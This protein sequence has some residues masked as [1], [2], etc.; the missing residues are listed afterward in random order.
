VSQPIQAPAASLRIL[1][2]DDEANIRAALSRFLDK[3]G[4]SVVTVDS[5]TGALEAVAKH[6]FDAIFLDIRMPDIS[7]INVFEQWQ[8]EQPR[9]AKRVVFLTGDIVSEDLQTFLSSTGRPFIAKPFNLE[10]VLQFLHR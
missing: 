9:L 7:G 8:K 5:G 2:A 4:H 6:A 1:V 3:A 10:D